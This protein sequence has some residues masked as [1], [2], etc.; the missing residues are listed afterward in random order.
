M[1]IS[2]FPIVTNQIL[3]ADFNSQPQQLAQ[4][5]GY[6]IQA[7]ITGTPTGTV[8]LQAS[9]DPFLDIFPGNEPPVHW[10]DIAGS[11]FTV[12]AAG[13]EMWNVI[14]AFYNWVRIAYT[15]TS[16][17]ASTAT[18]TATVNIKGV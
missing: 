16:G 2:N 5:Y 8:K 11:T 6:C 13:S 4:I 18:M 10:T 12:S 1:R 9:N 17:G 15:D 14:G 7:V 3:N